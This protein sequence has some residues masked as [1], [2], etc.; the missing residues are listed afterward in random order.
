MKRNSIWG[1]IKIIGN[2]KN[3]L[4][5]ELKKDI[6]YYCPRYDKRVTAKAGER[7]D[8]ATGAIDIDSRAWIIHDVLCRDGC[9]DDGSKCNNR[10][11]SQILSDILRSEGRWFRSV[12]WYFA[13][14]LFG[15]GQARKNGMF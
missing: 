11:A 8:G 15:G 7:F 9:F 4:R 12:T 14:W 1:Y 13:T 6:G 3:G 5:Y 2:P 10:Q